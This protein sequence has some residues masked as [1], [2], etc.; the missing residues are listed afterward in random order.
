MDLKEKIRK[1]KEQTAPKMLVIYFTRD[2]V[3]TV[4]E[5]DELNRELRLLQ[6]KYP[7]IKTWELRYQ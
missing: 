1:L 6:Q 2:E 3:P 7:F 5:L 4:R